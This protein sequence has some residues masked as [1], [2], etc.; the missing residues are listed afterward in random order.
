MLDLYLEPAC[1]RRI[2]DF[3]NDLAADEWKIRLPWAELK[4][5]DPAG[6]VRLYLLHIATYKGSRDIR[7][8]LGRHRTDGQIRQPTSG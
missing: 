4:A 8:D 1:R 7:Q 5:Q 3:V 6:Y 2:W